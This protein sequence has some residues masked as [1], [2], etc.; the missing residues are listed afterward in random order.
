M[1]QL[2]QESG[3]SRL[4]RR[5]ATGLFVFSVLISTVTIFATTPSGQRPEASIGPWAAIKAGSL[6]ALAA[7][8]PDAGKRRILWL[9][10]AQSYSNAARWMPWRR[11]FY[12]DSAGAYLAA[13]SE[14]PALIALIASEQGLRF[15]D[16]FPDAYRLRSE[17]AATLRSKALILLSQ[18]LRIW[19]TVDKANGEVA[20]DD[21]YWAL[22]GRTIPVVE[23][24]RPPY[25]NELKEALDTC[26]PELVCAPRLG[27][28]AHRGM[29]SVPHDPA[30]GCCLLSM[31]DPDIVD[32]GQ[33][34]RALSG[35]GPHEASI[36]MGRIATK[37]YFVATAAR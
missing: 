35:V 21:P 9:A 26:P 6:A 19:R 7:K 16:D 13:G 18:S 23:G 8:E 22:G 29:L 25:P 10:A 30:W 11:D 3:M 28:V 27:D 15:A 20:A 5:A 32:P 36:R 37:L 24:T 14:A 33:A 2:L 12:L 4:T 31:S 1:S 17:L 34:L